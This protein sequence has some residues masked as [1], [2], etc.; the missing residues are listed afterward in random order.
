MAIVLLEV[1][2]KFKISTSPGTRTGDLQDRSIVPQPTTLPRAALLRS[3]KK[4]YQERNNV[5][6][7]FD[8]QNV[9]IQRTYTH[10]KQ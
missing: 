4:N 2:G 3:K 5:N 6:D 10:N 7:T 1:L 8:S 9:K